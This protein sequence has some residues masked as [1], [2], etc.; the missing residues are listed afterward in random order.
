MRAPDPSRLGPRLRA[1]GMAAVLCAL[2]A[3]GGP[4]ATASLESAPL[5]TGVPAHRETFDEAPKAQSRVAAYPRKN[6]LPEPPADEQDK[7]GAIGLTA[8]AEIAPE[9]NEIQASTDR[10][11]LEVVGRSDQGRDLYLITL[12][13]PEG[14]ERVARQARFHRDM[15]HHP[16]QAAADQSSAQGYK[17]PI[18]INANMHGDEP[19]GTD[20]ALQVVRDYATSTEP[21]VERALRSTRIHILLS[22]NPDGRVEGTRDNAAGFDLNRDLLTASQPETQALR[23]VIVQ[24]APVLVLD[25][26]GYANGTLIE[27]TTAPFGQ[28]FEFDLAM[29]HALPN[30]VGIEQAI[31]DLD[32]G[33]RDDVRAPQIPLR[34]WNGGWDGW[35]PIFTAQYAAL[36][37]A[38]GQTVELPMKVNNDSYDLPRA[39]LRRRTGINID[40]AQAAMQATISY[41][42]VHR[43][44]LVAD[45]TE[46]LRRGVAGEPGRAAPF[47]SAAPP[48]DVL[49]RT[50]SASSTGVETE[51]FNYPRAYI[52]PAGPEQRSAL[53][54]TRLSQALID[55]GVE[56][57]VATRPVTLGG[58]GYSAGTF[59]VDMHQ[60]R[61][62]V[63]NA[64]L[65]DG[66]DASPLAASMYDISAWSLS[67]LW[68]A[69]VMTV[70]P[71]GVDDGLAASL[72]TMLTRPHFRPV[73]AEDL[74]P[75][76]A[77]TGKGPWRLALVAPAEV[78]VMNALLD[79]DVEVQYVAEGRNGASV[80]I[81]ANARVEAERIAQEFGIPLLPAPGAADRDT[82]YALRPLRVAAAASPPEIF[83]LREMGFDVSPIDTAAL[84]EGFEVSEI[85]AMF[86]SQ[87]LTWADLS[88]PAQHDLTQFLADG[89]GLV[90]RGRAGLRLNEDLDLLKVHLNPG[91][92]DAN[93]V[94][95]VTSLE[96]GIAAG[97]TPKTWVDNPTWFTDVA[98]TVTVDQRYADRNV[99][100]SGHWRA[101][102]GASDGPGDAAGQALIVHGVDEDGPTRGAGVA[103]FGSDPLFRAHPKGQYALVAR[104]LLWTAARP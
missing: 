51:A 25:V 8:F 89:G 29:N 84:N 103:L 100:V 94:V 12:T 98:D 44:E 23:N 22:A 34:D 37:G 45:Q 15:I 73:L 18:L 11:S 88:A 50:G 96:D 82:G 31:A 90:A 83:A 65:S 58:Q 32:Y 74:V 63:A 64:L 78:A 69:D 76:G 33:T 99:L 66:A 36:H 91:R 20:A 10:V 93:G 75:T 61:R 81:P 28:N 43:A 5:L 92:G 53:A 47:G 101:T 79:A 16:A 38:I 86:V 68:G 14:A 40:V 48:E 97:A 59:V 77:L 26:H 60:A 2:A 24:T 57:Q 87:G 56:V 70:A 21:A 42:D 46:G 102:P 30:A 3:L 19:E 55:H 1:F 72:A 104:A 7:A 95:A 80:L 71:G 41:A 17:A 35:A 52:I 62:G 54:A 27:P 39:E 4:A 67:A 9:L 6:R 13:E 85:D 49:M